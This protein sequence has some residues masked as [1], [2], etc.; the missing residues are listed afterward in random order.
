MRLALDTSAWL[1][2]IDAFLNLDPAATD[3]VTRLR[4]RL[5][6]VCAPAGMVLGLGLTILHAF[7]ELTGTITPYADP[8]VSALSI[9]LP[10]LVSL[11]EGLTPVLI[12]WTR[13][14]TVGGWWFLGVI[15]TGLLPFA[16]F[17]F[18]IYSP[19]IF[20][21]V[22]LPVL[23]GLF[24]SARAATIGTVI[25]MAYCLTLPAISQITDPNANDHRMAAEQ[26]T[27]AVY[28]SIAAFSLY[29]ATMCFAVFYNKILRDVEE[30]RAAAQ[31]ASEA[32]STFLAN[33]SHELRTPLNGV[34]GFARLLRDIS[35][36][37]KASI[38]ADKINAS[39][40][41]LLAL[42]NDV[43]DISKIEAEAMEL[44]QTPLSVRAVI[45]DVLDM[46]SSVASERGLTLEAHVDPG[47]HDAFIGD[48]VRLRQILLN[49]IGNALKFTPKGGITV[50]VRTEEE[51]DAAT[52]LRF[53]VTDTGIGI[54]AEVLPNVFERFRQAD[55][56]TTREFG[57]TGLGLAI[58][59]KLSELMGGEIG[60]TSTVGK[61]STF[62]FT[63][64]LDRD[65]SRV[66]LANEAETIVPVM[67]AEAGKRILVAEDNATN[68]L[69]IETLLQRSGYQCHLVET[70]VEALEALKQAPFDLVLLDGHMPR[71]GGIEAA[72]AIRASGADYAGIPIVALTADTMSGQRQAYLDAG[73]DDFL[74]KPVDFEALIAKIDAL[75]GT[76]RKTAPPVG[77]KPP[78]QPAPALVPLKAAAGDGA[79]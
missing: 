32:K 36:D 65:H 5:L 47:V 66:P 3:E 67:L 49:L 71:M 72:Q 70:G 75:T 77:S 46:Q 44:E 38:Y 59:R 39:G 60:V 26:W 61:G 69:L 74:S 2:R 6:S 27:H 28:A 9:I 51:T 8:V 63:V 17:K 56:S 20:I 25:V 76:G 62:W 55:M 18:G 30:A 40:E 41:A 14:V 15:M 33:M 19:N 31:R 48:K 52:L 34:L 11:L 13:S 54:P 53:A 29:L 43:L 21:V 45:E 7:E 64:R 37:D 16:L 10:A 1:A 35:E 50:D 57:G 22:A 12:R 42:L 23:F 78:E 73:M 58:C 24:I 79:H 68:Q 4:G